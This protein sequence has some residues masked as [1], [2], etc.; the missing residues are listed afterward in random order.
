MAHMHGMPHKEKC[1]K[2]T[3]TDKKRP[4]PHPIKRARVKKISG[5]FRNK[6]KGFKKSGKISI[7]K[8]L[9]I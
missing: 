3:R 1:Q 2:K 6:I 8:W 5:N 4:K 7:N 9:Q